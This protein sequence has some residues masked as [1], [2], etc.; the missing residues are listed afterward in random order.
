GAEQERWQIGG[1]VRERQDRRVEFD[2]QHVG[3]ERPPLPDPVPGP[4][5]APGELLPELLVGQGDAVF[6]VR[7]EVGGLRGRDHVNLHRHPRPELDV[8]VGIEGARHPFV[9]VDLVTGIEEEPEERVA[10]ATEDDVVEHL[11]LLADVERLV[12][13]DDRLEVGPDE[14]LDVVGD[15]GGELRGVTDDEAG[16]AVEGTPDSVG[17]GELIAV[18][19]DS[20][21]G[22]E[23]PEGRPRAGR[24]HEVARERRAVPLEKPDGF[25]LADARLQPEDQVAHALGGVAGGVLERGELVHLVDDPG[26]PPGS[27]NKSVAGTALSAPTMPRT[28]STMN[29]GTS[30][31]SGPR[32][33]HPTNPTRV[34]A[35]SPSPTRMS[36]KGRERSCGWLGSEKS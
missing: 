22:T 12:P 9:E 35:D 4:R 7:R 19:D 30:V 31:R 20:V 6:D 32:S 25:P 26:P 24:Q 8:G 33:F 17:D 29:H 16:P 36:R 15:V 5:V 13:L 14:L 23:Q 21:A 2:S 18:G 1:D 27:M 3:H 10:E 28:S 11:A 34:P